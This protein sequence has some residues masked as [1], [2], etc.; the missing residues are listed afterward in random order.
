MFVYDANGALVKKEMGGETTVYAGQHY[1]LNV[2][3]G[4]ETKH[5]DFN[6]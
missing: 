1:E 2:T 5:Y 6:G 3:M 4:Q